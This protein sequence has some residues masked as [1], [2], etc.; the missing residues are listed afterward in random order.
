MDPLGQEVPK[1][2]YT[3]SGDVVRC[4][5]EQIRVPIATRL[6]GNTNDAVIEAALAGWGLSRFQSYQVAVPI[7]TGGWSRY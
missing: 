2:V 4:R 6:T 1:P 5:G 7:E 3:G